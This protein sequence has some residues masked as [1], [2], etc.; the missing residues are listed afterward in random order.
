VQ[1]Q[2]YA[3]GALRCAYSECSSFEGDEQ[4]R[5]LSLR[6]HRV[7][8]ADAVT[9]ME[10]ERALTMPD[11]DPQDEDRF[12]TLETD[13]FGRVLVVVYVER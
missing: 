6:K 12:V 8:F 10:D 2:S 3:T 7:D 5:V 4:K 13:L 1:Q 11:D 9:A